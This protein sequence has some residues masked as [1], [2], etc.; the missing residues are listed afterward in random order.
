MNK[1]SILLLTIDALRADMLSC[2]GYDRPTTPNLDRL[3]TSGIRFEQAITGGS[4]T[5][6]A[7]PVLLTSSYASVYGGCL[8]PLAPE[9]PSPIETLAADGYATGGFSTSPLLSKDYGYDRGFHHFAELVP[10]ESDPLLRRIKG[11]Q[12]LLRSPLTHYMMGLVGKRMRP[13]RN[14]VSA[15]EVTDRVCRWLDGVE[16]PFFVWAHYM[17]THWPYHLEET[18]THP[19]D[20]AQAWRELSMMH[21]VNFKGRSLT[22]TQRERFVKLYERALQYVDTQI[23]RLLSHLDSMGHASNTIIIV[24]SDHG[25]EFLEHG[26]WGHFE[27][28]LYD[29]ILKVPLIIHMPNWTD[30]QVIHRQVRTLDIMPTILDLCGCYCPDGTEGTSLVSLWTP[31]KAHYEEVEAISEMWRDTWHRIAVRTEAFKYIWDNRR[32]HQPELYD[33]RADPGERQNVSERHP[34]EVSRFQ[35]SVDA[36]LRRVAQTMPAS[37]SPEPELDEDV[38]SRLRGLGY[39]E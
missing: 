13:A 8:G 27:S 1:P 12:C 7:F 22:P 29:E 25:E 23:G 6:A 4:W 5:Q 20:I 3:A 36:H 28:N 2:Y 38:I 24:A 15:A 34:K 35:A 21:Q 11:G 16:S 32:P 14:Y 33:L 26:R 39:I 31:S 18:L 9:R 37:T 10:A 17:D 30:S 19:R